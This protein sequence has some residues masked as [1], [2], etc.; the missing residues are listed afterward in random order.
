MRLLILGGTFEARAL[1]E[2]IAVDGRI[3]AVLSLA[4]RTKKPLGQAVQCR[5]GDFGGV[6]GLVNWLKHEKIDAIVDATHPY[7]AQISRNAVAAARICGLPL[8]SIVRAPWERVAGDQWSEVPDIAASVEALGQEP[9]NVFLTVGRME[10]SQFAGAPQ[11]TY[12]ARTIDPPGDVSLPPKLSVLTARGPFD[13]EGETQLM[14]DHGIDRFGDQ[15]L[16]WCGDLCKN[17][18]GARAWTGR[19]YDRAPGKTVR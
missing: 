4:G 14:T 9:K 17:Y 7:A 5:T 3:R 11:H 13:V 19:C 16:W 6:D 10:L 12:L 2:H 15:E 18:S 1:A 8:G